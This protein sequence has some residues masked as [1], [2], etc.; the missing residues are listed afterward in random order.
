MGKVCGKGGGQVSTRDSCYP[1]DHTPPA[2]C[3]LDT[4]EVTSNIKIF[5]CFT[6]PRQLTKYVYA[7]DRAEVGLQL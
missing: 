5:V 6:I 4:S 7:Q 3:S 1:S 2:V